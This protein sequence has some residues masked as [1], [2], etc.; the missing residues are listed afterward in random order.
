VSVVVYPPFYYWVDFLGQPFQAAATSACQ[1]PLSELAIVLLE[2]FVIDP[3][4]K[5][6]LIHVCLLNHCVVENK[7][8][9]HRLMGSH[10]GFYLQPKIFR[11]Q[12]FAAP[13]RVI[14]S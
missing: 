2:G 4:D 7:A 14:E 6:I 11:S 5:L 3:A 8:S 13:K 1:L 9:L 12:T 10:K